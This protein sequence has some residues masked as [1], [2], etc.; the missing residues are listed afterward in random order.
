[1]ILTTER[2]ILRPFRDA[3]FEAVHEYASDE[4]VT[5]YTSF[6]PNSPEET[7]EFLA[8]CLAEV[9]ES[10]RQHYNLA[11]TLRGDD[12]AIGGVGFNIDHPRHDGAEMGYV[13]HPSQWGKGIA[14][15]ASSA[16]LR[17]A[18]DTVDL[19]RIVARCHPDNPASAAVMRKLGMTYEGRQR[20]VMWLKGAWWDFLVYSILAQEFRAPAG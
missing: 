9:D 7:R 16:I 10:P 14:T 2:L 6:G 5:R 3:D 13:L 20:E 11:I 12:R 4:A 15:E 8:R 1:M 17:Y 18:F 19:H